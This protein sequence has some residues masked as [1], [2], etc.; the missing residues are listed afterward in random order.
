MRAKTLD[1]VTAGVERACRTVSGAV[2]LERAVCASLRE[3]VPFDAWCA[4]TV[5]PGSVL[6]TGGWHREGLPLEYMN[7]ML[8]IEAGGQDALA[9]STM[10]RSCRRA[11]TLTAATGGQPERSRHYREIL[12]PAG[13]TRE[14]RVLFGDNASVWGAL[15]LFRGADAPDFADADAQLIG[16]ATI[17][18][19]T[20]IRREMVLTE[21]TA[22]DTAAG[23]GLVLL[24]RD[25]HPTT[26]SS[27]AARWLTQVDD[28]I[29][30]HRE[31]PFCVLTLAH[32]AWSRPGPARTR[33]RSRTGRWLTLHAEQLAGADDQVSIIIEAARPVEIAALIADTYRLTSRERDVVGLIARGFARTE[34]ARLLTVSAYT[35]DDHIKRVFGKLEVRSRAEL[36]AKLFFD[37]HLPRIENEVPIGGTGWFL[38]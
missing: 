7:P 8:E 19:A 24:D 32:Q 5:D 20:A 23:P 34:I 1:Q 27:A 38:R 3:A 10:A 35:V 6:P 31:L 36:T 29:D 13:M 25:L 37:Q 22:D 12:V 14:M 28:G 26:M 4:L 17:S 33:I 2:E 18:V 21:I 9:L 30:P 15:V 16:D 11:M